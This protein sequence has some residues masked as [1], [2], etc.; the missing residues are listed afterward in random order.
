[1][2]VVDLQMTALILERS[3]L[4]LHLETELLKIPRFS[5]S[6]HVAIWKATNQK[7]NISLPVCLTYEVFLKGVSKINRTDT[8][9]SDFAWWAFSIRVFVTRNV[10]P[11]VI[12][13]ELECRQIPSGWSSILFFKGMIFLTILPYGLFCSFQKSKAF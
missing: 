5:R 7:W 12:Y 10:V 11:T 13:L 8:G 4:V 3:D 1:M 9:K 2:F 6:E